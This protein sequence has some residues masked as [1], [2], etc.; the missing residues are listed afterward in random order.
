MRNF[1]LSLDKKFYWGAGALAGLL[2]AGMISMIGLFQFTDSSQHVSR[3]LIRLDRVLKY[4]SDA[5]VAGR[6]FLATGSD[7]L[8]GPYNAAANSITHEMDALTGL[9]QNNPAQKERLSRLKPLVTQEFNGIR[10]IIE[11]KKSQGV[12][13]NQRLD[14]GESA[15]LL[16]QIRRLVKE[17]KDAELQRLDFWAEKADGDGRRSIHFLL[18]VN[19]IAF[20]ISIVSL[21]FLY[22]DINA[23]QQIEDKFK[24]TSK[25]LQI[26]V[27]DLEQR[28]SEFTVLSD[29]VDLL[30]TCV[31]ADEAYKA[32]AHSCQIL[33]PGMQGALYLIDEAKNL[34]EIATE[35][36]GPVVGETVFQADDCWALRRGRLYEA[37]A[38]S[39]QTCG[40]LAG[41]AFGRYLCVP[42]MGQGAALGFLHL[43]HNRETQANGSASAEISESKKRLILTFTE[44]AALALAN[45]R[46]R[47]KLHDQSIHDPLT[48]LFNRRYMQ[49]SLE[50]ELRRSARAKKPLGLIMMDID[51]FKKF[52]DEYGHDAGDK[53]LVEIGQ[54]IEKQFREYDIPCRYGGEEFMVL[55]P[56]TTLEIAERRAEQLR[57]S[58][59][60]VELQYKGEI[61]GPVSLSLG[62]AVY[63]FHGQTPENLFRAADAALYQ[64]KAGGRNCVSVAVAPSINP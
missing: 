48:G 36:N 37:D 49:D 12:R 7:T 41:V 54:H 56:E 4:V 47:Q 25:K 57:K 24:D 10:R 53:L 62:V 61:L 21:F 11:L 59:K 44:Q 28:N 27:E 46:L 3:T 51:H 45:L 64:A 22:R 18:I 42:M 26:W 50:R 33:F 38:D 1:K 8:L 32:I 5:E 15:E 55:M 19:L 14:R 17:M 13:S 20:A 52:N 39:G 29:T 31:A 9:T 35:W 30:H 23:R 58:M 40:H 43:R 16:T 63:P 60:N 2:V 6:G 34:V